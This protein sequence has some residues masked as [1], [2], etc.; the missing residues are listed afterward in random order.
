MKFI[1]VNHVH[2]DMKKQFLTTSYFSS[3]VSGYVKIV[4]IFVQVLVVA[5]Q[6]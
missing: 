3:L 4:A 5:A 2:V 6:L 1:I